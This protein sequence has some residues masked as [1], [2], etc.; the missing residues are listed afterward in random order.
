MTGRGPGHDQTRPVSTNTSLWFQ[1]IDRTRSLRGLDAVVSL[2]R[3]PE[4]KQRNRTRCEMIGASGY[5]PV[6]SRGDL[7]RPVTYDRTWSCVRSVF[8]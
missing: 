1:L 6:R 2:T 7:T 8:Q 5:V 3:V 4:G